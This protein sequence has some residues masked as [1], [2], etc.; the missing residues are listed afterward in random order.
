MDL[1]NLGIYEHIGGSGILSLHDFAI[2]RAETYAWDWAKVAR[3]PVPFYH[4]YAE[5]T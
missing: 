2:Q 4:G 3:R 1:D 5:S